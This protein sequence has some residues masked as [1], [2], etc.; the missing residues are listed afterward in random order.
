MRKWWGVCIL[1]T[2]VTAHAAFQFTPPSARASGMAGA[3][4][5][6]ANDAAAPFYNPAGLRR[7]VSH[8]GGFAYT[9]PHA[10]VADVVLSL[11]TGAYAV[12]V[13]GAG[14]FGVAFAQFDG[15]GL[16]QE[17]VVAL[18]YALRLNDLAMFRTLGKEAFAGVN[19]K[20]LSHMFRWDDTALGLADMGQG[21]FIRETSGASGITA[22]FGGLVRV[23]SPI[24]IG[25]VIAN[26]TQPDVGLVQSDPVP[27]ELRIGGS[28]HT[29]FSGTGAA[30]RLTVSADA[31]YRNQ[32]WGADTDKVN[33]MT[34]CEVAFRGGF[35]V[36]GGIGLHEAAVGFGYGAP[37]DS[38]GFAVG[39][40]DYAYTYSF[41]VGD[42]VGTHC[43]TAGF[44]FG[45]P[46]LQEGELK[47]REGFRLEDLLLPE[48]G[49]QQQLRQP[50]SPVEPRPAVRPQQPAPVTPATVMPPSSSTD[51]I[52][53]PGNL[54][55]EDRKQLD[56]K[57]EENLLEKL[58][59]TP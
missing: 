24:Y 30:Q 8:S 26:I 57:K 27:L 10:G 21:A 11:M 28:F 41:R 59:Q 6:L 22:D 50:L 32:R 36:R 23:S 47:V 40:F 18:G 20:M 44:R 43:V 34:G 7:V 54:T 25:G 9:K 33:I 19:L 2:T 16:Y 38:R 14:T 48:G 56:R 15:D 49:T 13:R 31:V 52:R 5:G 55:E 17:T 46:V 37:L 35:D 12:P 45:A 42:V 51:T 58:L 3:F 29:W 1:G 53:G 4:V 39:R